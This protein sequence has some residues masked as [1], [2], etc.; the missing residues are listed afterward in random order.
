MLGGEVKRGVTGRTGGVWWLDDGSEQN[1]T[2]FIV[3]K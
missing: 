2:A 1:V 3:S